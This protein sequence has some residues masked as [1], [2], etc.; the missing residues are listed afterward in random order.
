MKERYDMYQSLFLL[1][2]LHS[3]LIC[4]IIEVAVPA[5]NNTKYIL[6]ELYIKKQIRLLLIYI[7]FIGFYLK[8]L[9]LIT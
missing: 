2:L 1:G 5:N 8:N 4:K 6:F 9:V 3:R 7:Y